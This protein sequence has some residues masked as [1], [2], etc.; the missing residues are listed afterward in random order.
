MKQVKEQIHLEVIYRSIA[1]RIVPLLLL[2]TVKGFSQISPTGN[3]TRNSSRMGSISGTILDSLTKMPLDH[4][5]V[6]LFKKPFKD[7][8]EFTSK[9]NS[10]ALTQNSVFSIPFRSFGATFTYNF[11]KTNSE[12]KKRPRGVSNDDVKQGE[13]GNGP[14]R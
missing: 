3:Q 14:G 5:T 1:G 8:K 11:G 10:G 6:R 9:I 12:I 2:L 13:G 7:N 4:A